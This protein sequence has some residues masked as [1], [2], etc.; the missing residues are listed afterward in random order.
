MGVN[1]AIYAFMESAAP[2]LVAWSCL[3]TIVTVARFVRKA[4]SGIERVPDSM[5][6]TELAGLPLTLLQ[7][8]CFVWAVLSA[9]L[10]SALLFLWWGPGFVATAIAIVVAKRRGTKI[11]WRPLRLWISWLC[12]LYYLAYMSVFALMHMP[13]MMFAFSVWIINDQVEKAFMS[14]DADRLR[15]TFHDAWLFRL[16]YPFGLLLPFALDGMPYR[17]FAAAYAIVLLGLWIGGIVYVHRSGRLH[18]LPDDPSLLRNMVYLRQ[19]RP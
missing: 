13:A 10:L 9:D 2:Y 3:F 8:V 19:E 14:Q 5:F 17:P 12:K 18:K 15:R 6:F 11:D 7:P 4:R 16:L 1:A